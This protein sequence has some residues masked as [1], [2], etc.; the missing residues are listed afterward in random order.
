M[1]DPAEVEIYTPNYSALRSK[2]LSQ[3]E[4]ITVLN[5]LAREL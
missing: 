4:S 1:E 3:K 5:R 2:A